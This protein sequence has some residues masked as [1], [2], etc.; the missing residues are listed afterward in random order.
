MKGLA[1]NRQGFL[2]NITRY[3]R[4]FLDTDFRRQRLPK[5]QIS[6]QDKGGNLTGINIGKYPQLIQAIWTLLSKPYGENNSIKISRGRYK[7]KINPQLD[8]LISKYIDNISN[9]SVEE[10]KKRAGLISRDLVSKFKTDPERLKEEV[11]NLLERDFIRTLVVP[12]LKHLETYFD[13]SN[14]QGLET[15]FDIEDELGQRLISNEEE[16]VGAA[17]NTAIITSDFTEFDNTIADITNLEILK[18]KIKDYFHTFTSS[19][20]YN[21]LHSLRTTLQ[22]QENMEIYLYACDVNYQNISFPIFYLPL[23]IAL[24]GSVFNLSLNPHLYINKKAIDYVGED[25][26]RSD[27]K[28][29]KSLI[30]DRIIYLEPDQSFMKIMQG[31]VDTW[32]SDFALRPPIDLSNFNKQKARSI[33]A[34]MTNQLHFAAFDKSD[35]SLL[36]DY[37]SLLTMLESDDPLVN[38]F[39][40]LVDGFLNEDPLNI[41]VEVDREWQET[42]IQDRLVYRSPIPLNEEQQ[43]IQSAVKNKKSRFIVC[44]GPP[45]TGKSHTIAALAFDAIL[46]GRN[47]LILSDKKE[48]LDVVEDKVTNILNSVRHDDEFQN[49][50]LRMGKSANTYNKIMSNHSIQK[51]KINYQATK[52]AAKNLKGNINSSETDLKHT[53]KSISDAYEQIDIQKIISLQRLEDDLDI[54]QEDFISIL[55]DV[56]CRKA[57]NNIKELKDLLTKEDNKLLNILLSSSDKPD[58]DDLYITIDISNKLKKY[59]NENNI[60]KDIKSLKIFNSFQNHQLDKLAEFIIRYEEIKYPMFGFL[61]TK[62]KAKIIDVDFKNTFDCKSVLEIYKNYKHF[63][64]TYSLLSNINQ[65]LVQSYQ[66]GR[67]LKYAFQLL[68]QDYKLNTEEKIA[69][70]K[71]I[72]NSKK[73]LSEYQEIAFKLGLDIDDIQSIANSDQGNELLGLNEFID[74]MRQ[75]SEIYDQ[76]AKIPKADYAGQMSKLQSLHTT[77]LANTID[78]R[79]IDFYQNKHATAKTIKQIIRKKQ[80]FPKDQFDDLKSAFPCIIANI[81]DYAEY[82][83]LVPEL[84]DLIIIDEASQ[85]SIA[86]AFPAILRA[87]KMVVFGDAKQFSNVKTSNASKSIN[88]QYLNQIESDFIKDNEADAAILN[89]LS[90]FNIKTSVL[91]FVEMMSNYSIMLRKHFRGYKEH[92]SYSSKYFYGGQLQTIKLRG[93]SIEEVLNFKY[94]EDDGK[95]SLLGNVNELEA[96]YII[97]ELEKYLVIDNPPT[98]G[99]I[100]PFTDQQKYV[101]Q[102]C[103]KHKD[104]QKFYEKLKLKVMT[105]DS[106]QGEEREIVFYSMVATESHDRLYGIFP[107]SRENAGDPETTL[108]LQRLNVG[109]SRVQEN[110]RFLLSKP[111]DNYN[112]AIG[113]ALRHYATT[114]EDAKSMPSVEDVDVNSP[115]ER[116]VLEWIFQTQYYQ[117]NSEHIEVIP[118]F[119]IGDYLKQLHHTYNHPAYRV[120][121][122]IRHRVDENIHHLIIEYD[123]FKE[124]FTNLDDVDSRNYQTYYK[125]DDVEREKILETYGYKILRINRFNIGKD[126]V[127]T[128]SERIEQLFH[129]I[130]KK[131]TPHDLINNINTV[132]DEI[133]TGERIV[134]NTCNE[135]KPKQ[136]F[137]D[138]SLKSGIGRKCKECKSK[139]HTKKRKRKPRKKLAKKAIGIVH[140]KNNCPQCGSSMILRSGKYGR[141]FGCSTFPRCRGTRR[142]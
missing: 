29:W 7:A 13:E 131:N 82:M 59:A 52:A 2:S 93:K 107:K 4:D 26:A 22:I 130:K 116:K 139:G 49:P 35:E 128:L 87:K 108:R 135:P 126:P 90:M 33:N 132:A 70:L 80:K 125:S 12:L 58:L 101:T 74:Y 89:R 34:V 73:F 121:F 17:L 112:G 72:I 30:S 76:F 83:P 100:T 60:K 134:C 118:Q 5:R 10:I 98:V 6:R 79:V 21:E 37:E 18:L 53:I 69:L 95:A 127:A 56:S 122:L 20:F 71:I 50:I 142:A 62:D 32:A 25:I 36:N 11:I 77:T 63:K 38:D 40:K 91:D 120:D 55:N 39:K 99:V 105:F 117:N 68:A 67:Y 27:K 133:S 3:F 48:A 51:I 64:K 109:F 42:P 106:C 31:L 88:I 104:G 9:N 19:D 15:I 84:F 43:K 45:G 66:H 86:Q 114:I 141:F 140:G 129:D 57:V 46:D 24:S 119:P 115:M 94:I 78:E 8:N 44:S 138:S 123:G 96:E 124:H 16:I 47:I 75:Y 110:M 1:I 61:F 85:V 54:D 81:R 65:L 14:L 103:N 97:T 23:D 137:L 113:E 102:Q 111:L 41:E 136:Q 92:I 28:A